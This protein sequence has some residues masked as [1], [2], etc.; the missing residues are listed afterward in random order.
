M[1][2]TVSFFLHPYLLAAY[3]MA[4]V[5]AREKLKQYFAKGKDSV[6]IVLG[7][8][9]GTGKSTLVNS[10]V[11]KLMA[12]EG[13]KV[14][15]VTTKI[16]CYTKAVDIPSELLT[17]KRTINVMVWDTPGLGDPFGD[18]EATAIEIAEKCKEADL[19]VYC[20]D[21]RGRFANDDATGI[22]LLTNALNQQMW[23]HAIFVLTFAN[24]VEAKDDK[25][26]VTELK[27]KIR[28]WT[29][30]IKHLMK[31]LK[32]PHNIADNI[33]IIP[34]GYRHY[35]PPGIDDW[36][37]PFWAESFIKT[38]PHA[39]PALLGINT[40]RLSSEESASKDHQGKASEEPH[41]M[42]IRFSTDDLLS[43]RTAVATGGCAGVGALIGLVAGAA[44][45]PVTM[46]VG[47]AIGAAAGSGVGFVG[48][49]ILG[50]IFG[51]K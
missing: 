45:G 11:G 26:A 9:M 23:K 10:I 32:F 27:D 30:A 20:L 6:E 13:N 38:K 2:D 12:E 37:S 5:K 15:S 44:G 31:N 46:P 50:S 22:E 36:F 43:K 33:S 39:Q 14:V 34:A 19:L 40:G 48:R 42:P 3:K 41:E 29:D 21:I 18:D 35:Q 16:V 8:K 47:A 7:G 25:D 28:S 4:E 51:I 24:E 49:A 1:F 17:D